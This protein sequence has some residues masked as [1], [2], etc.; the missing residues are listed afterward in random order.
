[1]NG[2]TAT[3]GIVL[4]THGT[5]GRALIDVAEFILGQSLA[6]IGFVS[7]RQPALAETGDREILEALER[8]NRG[9]GVL[10]MTDIGGASPHN[11]VALLLPNPGL[12]LLSGLNLA[13]LIRAWNYRDRPPAELREIAAKGAVREIGAG[14][15]RL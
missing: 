3:T 14:K 15:M 8:A 4:V 2:S 13:M 1:M 10:V 6:E 9:Q 11:Q 7:F 5:I 12:A